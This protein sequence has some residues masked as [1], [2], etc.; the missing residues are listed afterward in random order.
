MYE[1][2]E[3]VGQAVVYIVVQNGILQRQVVVEFS[4]FAIDSTALGEYCGTTHGVL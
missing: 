3:D 4:T 1:V 2:S